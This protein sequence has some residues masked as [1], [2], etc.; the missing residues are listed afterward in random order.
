MARE[1]CAYCKWDL[2]AKDT[3]IAQR[4]PNCKKGIRSCMLCEADNV[5]CAISYIKEVM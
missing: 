4:C 5:N 2:E 1:Y 3:L